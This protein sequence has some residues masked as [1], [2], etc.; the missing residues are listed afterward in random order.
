M[1]YIATVSFI[2]H[3]KAEDIYKDIAKDV[4]TSNFEIDRRLNEGKGKKVIGQMED[5]LGG[6]RMKKLMKEFFG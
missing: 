2:I 1:C 5:E 3:V 6:Q 4:D